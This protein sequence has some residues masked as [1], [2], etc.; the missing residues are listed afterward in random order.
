MPP[1]KP[2]ARA[3]EG[4]GVDGSRQDGVRVH[5]QSLV[6]QFLSRLLTPALLLR[7]EWAADRP[8][9]SG[10]MRGKVLVRVNMEIAQIRH[11]PIDRPGAAAS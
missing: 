10:D 2:S 5:K 11:R 8:S 9:G 7:T 4:S 1:K 3:L 6:P